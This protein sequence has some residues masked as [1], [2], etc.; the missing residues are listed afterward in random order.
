MVGDGINDAPALGAA[1]VGVAMGVAGSAAAMETADVALLT[2]DL[3]RVA[4]AAALGKT[5]VR[6]IQEN[7]VFS[8]VAKGIVLALSLTGRTRLWMAVVAD[9]GTALIVIFNGLTVLNDGKID[10]ER[11]SRRRKVDNLSSATSSHRRATATR[12]EPPTPSTRPNSAP[13]PP[14]TTRRKGLAGERC[15]G[16]GGWRCTPPPGSC[17]RTRRGCAWLFETRGRDLRRGALRGFSRPSDAR[18][19]R[20]DERRRRPGRAANGWRAAASR[21]RCGERRT[22]ARLSF[23][24]VTRTTRSRAKYDASSS[25]RSL[26][27]T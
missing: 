22:R 23:T 16:D 10:R 5:C 3:G 9:V 19:G 4:E 7:I 2:N 25:S 20:A 13:L 1:D 18:T 27:T 26:T 11:R 24:L 15:S 12:T 6:K 14:H 21:A 8:I 17:A